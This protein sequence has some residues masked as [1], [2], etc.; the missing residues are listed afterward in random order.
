MLQQKSSGRGKVP[1]VRN[2]HHPGT[3]LRLVLSEQIAQQR[4]NRAAP[5]V[6]GVLKNLPAVPQANIVRVRK[7][8]VRYVVRGLPVQVLAENFDILLKIRGAGQ[9]VKVVIRQHQRP[10]EHGAGQLKK[11]LDALNGGLPRL[12]SGIPPVKALKNANHPIDQG[13]GVHMLL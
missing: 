9:V 10:S 1:V 4:R 7:N 6:D 12:Q 5:V 2:V 8:F 11:L 3:V 13:P